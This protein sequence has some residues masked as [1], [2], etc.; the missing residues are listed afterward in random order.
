M[1]Y[2]VSVFFDEETD[3]AVRVLWRSIEAAG[4]SSFL[5]Q[6]P[7][8]PHL[9]LSVVPALD[10]RSFRESLTKIAAEQTSFPVALASIGIFPGNEGVVFLAATMTTALLHLHQQV[11]DLLKQHELYPAIY[12]LPDHWNPHCSVARTLSIEQ[13]PATVALCQKNIPDTLKGHITHIGIVETPSE[14]ELCRIP[15]IFSGPKNENNE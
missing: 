6:G 3:A 14:V 7:F 1:A 4:L 10:L 9:T 2:A 8:H 15:L 11:N 13:V 12:Y 5:A